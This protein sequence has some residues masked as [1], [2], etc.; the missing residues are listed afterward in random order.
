MGPG[1]KARSTYAHSKEHGDISQLPLQEVYSHAV[2][3]LIADKLKLMWFLIDNK[4]GTLTNKRGC[5]SFDQF[6]NIIHRPII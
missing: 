4:E 3:S 6:V 5:Y 2:I 1:N